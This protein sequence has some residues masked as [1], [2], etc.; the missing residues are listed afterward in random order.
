MLMTEP[1]SFVGGTDKFIQT[2]DAT[3]KGIAVHEYGAFIIPTPA[4]NAPA[5]YTQDVIVADTL[6]RATI[7][8][9]NIAPGATVTFSP[10]SP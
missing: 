9:A 7:T 1:N 6:Y 3:E 10:P 8:V 4:S 5:S 2:E